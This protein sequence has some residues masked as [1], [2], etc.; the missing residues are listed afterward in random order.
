[1]QGRLP[2]PGNPGAIDCQMQ[3]PKLLLTKLH[4]SLYL[5][6]LTDIYHIG[7]RTLT[8][9]GG[10]RLCCSLI[11][12]CNHHLSTCLYQTPH[13]FCAYSRGASGDQ[14][15]SPMKIKFH[16]SSFK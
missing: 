14:C 12:I 1:M 6:R 11:S 15:H 13:Y 10:Q 9:I 5:G 16:Y 2:T 8:K 4:Q 3:G 7:T